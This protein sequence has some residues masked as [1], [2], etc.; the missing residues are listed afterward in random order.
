MKKAFCFILADIQE[1]TGK[2]WWED[3]ISSQPGDGVPQPWAP[4]TSQLP[5]CV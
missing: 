4:P 2:Q 5:D 1:L 3:F